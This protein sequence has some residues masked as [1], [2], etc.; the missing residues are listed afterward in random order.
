MI[1]ELMKQLQMAEA[2]AMD[3][4][5]GSCNLRKK[6]RFATI[7]RESQEKQQIHE[8]QCEECGQ[9]RAA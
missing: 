8:Q 3:G 5:R 7:F 2:A 9:Q 4:Y 6:A 1:C